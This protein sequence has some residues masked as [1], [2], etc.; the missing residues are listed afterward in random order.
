[1]AY[2]VKIAPSALA[3]IEAVFLWLKER[4]PEAADR[5]QNGLIGTILSLET[6]PGRCAL[7]P[8]SEELGRDVRQLLYGKGR[9]RYRILFEMIGTETVQVYRLRHGARE[10]LGR[11]EFDESE[12]EE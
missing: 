10:S 3:D 8:E 9:I 2:Q 12:E 11:E 7:A 1:M 4:S 5:W 6:L